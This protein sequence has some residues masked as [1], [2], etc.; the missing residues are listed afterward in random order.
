MPMPASVPP[1]NATGSAMVS[2]ATGVPTT[3]SSLHA[4]PAPRDHDAEFQAMDRDNN[5]SLSRQEAASDKYMLRAF[6]G[7][8]DNHDGRLERDEAMRWLEN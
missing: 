7:L 8:D 2:D 6:A 4:S 3:V 5:G 1:A